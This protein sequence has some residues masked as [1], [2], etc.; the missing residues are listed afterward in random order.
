MSQLFHRHEAPNN[1]V[2][3]AGP[4]VAASAQMGLT[5]D[6]TEAEMSSDTQSNQDG[7]HSDTR[8]AMSGRKPGTR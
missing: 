5:R 6:R 7:D 2:I 1:V 3:E 4:M 8:S